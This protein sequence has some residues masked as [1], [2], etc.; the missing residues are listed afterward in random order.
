MFGL[1]LDAYQAVLL[2]AQDDTAHDPIRGYALANFYEMG[3]VVSEI[4][5]DPSEPE[6]LRSLLNGI[7]MEAKQRSIPPQGQLTIAAERGTQAVL[8]QFFGPTLHTVDDSALHGYIP[9]MIRPLG[10][11]SE[12]PFTAAGALFWPLDAY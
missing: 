8:Q 9:F 3:F 1:Y 6:L 2:T 10:D 4:A 11:E 12:N 5:A 7:A